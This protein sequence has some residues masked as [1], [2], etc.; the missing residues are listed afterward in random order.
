[1]PAF[2]DPHKPIVTCIATSC[3][4]CP[5]SKD[6]HCH[7]QAPD[8][9]HFLLGVAPVFV[10]GG[11]GVYRLGGWWLVPWLVVV[12]GYF[13]LLEIR[14]MCAHCPHYAEPGSTLKCWANYGAPK[15]W[16]YR[17]G[18]MSGVEKFLFLGGFAVIGCYP[19]ALMVA[20]GQWFLLSVYVL[21]TAAFVATLKKFLCSQCMNFACPL[22]SVDEQV[23]Q[24]FFA[25]NPQIAQ[26]WGVDTKLAGK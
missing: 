14:V 11:A 10:V 3:E 20:G 16:A 13:L 21:S 25:R 5:V 6:L 2:L 26:A 23:R 22:N 18:P 9:A 15:L 7:F 4:G 19:L 24:E 12:L 1:M 17:P 8:L